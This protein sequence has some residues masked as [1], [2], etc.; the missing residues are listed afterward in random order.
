MANKVINNNEI[1]KKQSQQVFDTFSVLLKKH[2]VEINTYATELDTL[3][4]AISKQASVYSNTGTN[5]KKQ[6]VLNTIY[7]TQKQAQT[8]QQGV[9]EFYKKGLQYYYNLR[10]EFTGEK[11]TDTVY[12]Q[13]KD[14]SGGGRWVRAQ[15]IPFETLMTAAN[16]SFILTKEQKEQEQDFYHLKAQLSVSYKNLLNELDKIGYDYKNAEDVT[17]E[18]EKGL[19]I[20]EKYNYKHKKLSRS[21]KVN[22]GNI[23][24]A[25]E[26]M[27]Q[28]PNTYTELTIQNINRVK[29]N[30]L[31]GLLG[32]DVG[33][34]QV[35]GLSINKNFQIVTLN[36]I[37]SKL[38]KMAKKINEILSGGNI[39]L[40]K[41]QQ[42]LSL[43]YTDYYSKTDDAIDK[44]VLKD[45]NDIVKAA[46]KKRK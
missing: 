4:T 38:K 12:I 23:S 10:T 30:W 31:S 41:I 6:T 27:K 7:T 29:K 35:K 42:F 46:T 5:Y 43:F 39:T 2:Q 40:K 16:P 1:L 33:S 9:E 22:I 3:K 8:I 45:I 44:Q 17:V 13:L 28:K 14:K 24:E 21:D 18:M 34:V 25:I 32:G 20:Q 11:I 26:K 36:N 19:E 15:D 37:T